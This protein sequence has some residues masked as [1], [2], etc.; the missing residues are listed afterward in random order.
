MDGWI[1]LD[2]IGL[3]W[4]GRYMETYLDTYIDRGTN[5]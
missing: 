1:G 5:K 3:D 2:W 4:I